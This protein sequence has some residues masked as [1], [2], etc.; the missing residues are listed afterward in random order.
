MILQAKLWLGTISL[1]KILSREKLWE[2]TNVGHLNIISF[3]LIVLICF[4]WKMKHTYKEFSFQHCCVMR[5]RNCFW[6]LKWV[7]FSFF[8]KSQSCQ[9]TLGYTQHIIYLIISRKPSKQP[10][11]T[12]PMVKNDIY[13]DHPSTVD[14]ALVLLC[15][16]ACTL[17]IAG[18]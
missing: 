4:V 6:Y 3:F 2:N 14:K 5:M 7:V 16:W 18:F 10:V 13:R 17:L 8:K 15:C 11:F 1:L 9:R 12:I